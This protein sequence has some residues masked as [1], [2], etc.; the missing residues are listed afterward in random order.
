MAD[1]GVS[2]VGT[3]SSKH[4]PALDRKKAEYAGPY[5]LL[6][7]VGSYVLIAGIIF[8]DKLTTFRGGMA[9]VKVALDPVSGRKVAVKIVDK[10]KLANP[11]E[12]V[13]MAREITIMKLL[14]HP[15]VLRLYDIY[16]SE[17]KMCA[18]TSRLLV[19]CLTWPLV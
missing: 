2:V 18:L 17:E 5:R 10:E 1:G 3:S 14:R 4:S 15:N 11:R 7:T 16:E 9:T 12:Q 6:E 19:V 8:F 13:S